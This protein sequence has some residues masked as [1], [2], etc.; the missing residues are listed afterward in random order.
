M[1]CEGGSDGG[2]IAHSDQYRGLK[3]SFAEP[4]EYAEPSPDYFQ[5]LDLGG[6]GL[7][8]AGYG[9]RSIEQMI[10][11]IHRVEAKEASLDDIDASLLAT[12]ANSAF[13]DRVIE[14]ARQS[15]VEGGREIKI[16]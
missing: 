7:T 8:P 15:I 1:Y 9:Y 13:N 11:A 16:V 6:P 2:L 14:A 5:Y 3:Y 10:A 12:A 4:P